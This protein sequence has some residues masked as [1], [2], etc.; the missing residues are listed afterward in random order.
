MRSKSLKV[1]VLF[2]LISGVVGV[3]LAWRGKRVEDRARQ[4]RVGDSKQSVLSELG[5][6][7][8]VFVDPITFLKHGGEVWAYG[9]KFD[10]REA[11]HGNS[12]FKLRLIAPDQADLVVVFDPD[13]L[14]MKVHLGDRKQGR[15]ISTTNSKTDPEL[16]HRV[17]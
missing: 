5:K 11:M 17:E 16:G 6:P 1:V 9:K 8:A 13:G 4:I 14:V 7:T 15:S 2:L 10:W 3:V 12:P